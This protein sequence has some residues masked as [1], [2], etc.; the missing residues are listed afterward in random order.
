MTHKDQMFKSEGKYRLTFVAVLYKLASRFNKNKKEDTIYIY[1]ALLLGYDEEKKRVMDAFNEKVKELKSTLTSFQASAEIIKERKKLPF[2][3][4]FA[5]CF[6]ESKEE[7]KSEVVSEDIKVVRYTKNN[8]TKG[9]LIN[10]LWMQGYRTTQQIAQQEDK[11][12]R[13]MPLVNKKK[14]ERLA[15]NKT[16]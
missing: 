5:H 12:N 11:R 15:K 4:P 7:I 3:N 14:E 1:D 16:P 9:K 10:D 8:L 13:I 6:I 2:E